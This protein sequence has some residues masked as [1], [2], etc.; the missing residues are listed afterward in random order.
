MNFHIGEMIREPLT[1]LCSRFNPHQA[2]LKKSVFS[3]QSRKNMTMM[4]SAVS[5]N[6]NS[7]PK[8]K[9]KKKLFSP[10]G[11]F[12]VLSDWKDVFQISD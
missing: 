8:E 9:K 6:T 12:E 7:Y 2:T 11:Y 4:E 5:P 3:G 1:F 10:Q